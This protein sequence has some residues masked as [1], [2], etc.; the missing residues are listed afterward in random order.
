MFRVYFVSDTAQVELTSGRVQA[1]ASNSRPNESS[2]ETSELAASATPLAN[3]DKSAK[4][5]ANDPE[6]PLE[7]PRSPEP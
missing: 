4:K 1:P 7:P 3:S 2:T 5:P 6:S